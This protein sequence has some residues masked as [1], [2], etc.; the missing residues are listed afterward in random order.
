MKAL[1]FTLLIATAALPVAARTPQQT[2]P[3][4][5]TAARPDTRMKLDALVVVAHPDD[6]TAIASY[7]AKAVFDDGRRVGVVYITDGEGGGNQIATERAAALGD[8]RQI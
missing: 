7:L 6:E 1:A 4:E 5:A 3:A 8:V 2:P